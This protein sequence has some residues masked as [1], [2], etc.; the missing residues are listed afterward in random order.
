MLASAITEP[1]SHPITGLMA[2]AIQAVEATEKDNS[3]DLPG[4][5][6]LL[7]HSARPRL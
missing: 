7:D 4:T 2:Q 1:E 3:T 5:W 6:A